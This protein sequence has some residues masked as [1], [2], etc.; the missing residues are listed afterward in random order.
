MTKKVIKIDYNNK[1]KI[2]TN[3]LI[4]YV[5]Y[6]YRAIPKLIS[7]IYYNINS[8]ETM[9]LKYDKNTPHLLYI[10]KNN[11]WIAYD[12]DYI[13][14]SLVLEIW[15]QLYDSYVN[16]EN[17]D[18]F[19]ESLVCDDTFDRIENFINDFRQFCNTGS[20]S[21]L[22]DQKKNALAFIMFLSKKYKL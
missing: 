10:S 9:N 8:R 12:K 2:D 1:I 20:S 13:L 11:K 21:A 18:E 4:E 17:M 22:V 19:K 16:I 15:R 14:D 3:I 7:N 6:H 5:K